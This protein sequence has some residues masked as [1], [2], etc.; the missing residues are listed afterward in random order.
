[1]TERR[2]RAAVVGSWSSPA[3]RAW[4]RTVLT[5]PADA[6]AALQ[7]L[8]AARMQAIAAAGGG[9]MVDTNAGA[10]STWHPSAAPR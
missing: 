8:I 1:M 9:M 4:S 2:E 10:P 5:W 3:P 7:E 6:D